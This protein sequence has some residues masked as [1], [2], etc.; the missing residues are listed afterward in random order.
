MDLLDH[1]HVTKHMTLVLKLS[2]R[3]P[4]PGASCHYM[5]SSEIADKTTSFSAFT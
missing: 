5:T 2:V 1:Q 3:S 4:D